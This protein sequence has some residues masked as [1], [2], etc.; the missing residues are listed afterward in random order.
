M[1]AMVAAGGKTV[2]RAGTAGEVSCSRSPDSAAGKC[3]PFQHR[4]GLGPRAEQR[5]RTNGK[6]RN[7]DM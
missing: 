5:R 2:E 3:W 7:R 1:D 4:L 6:H